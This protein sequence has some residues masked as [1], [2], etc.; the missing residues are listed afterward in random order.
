MT[1]L[2]EPSSAGAMPALRAVQAELANAGDPCLPDMPPEGCPPTQTCMPESNPDPRRSATKSEA[3]IPDVCMPSKCMPYPN[4]AS[5]A[6]SVSPRTQ[7]LPCVPQMD[8]NPGD[9][10]SC[11]PKKSS[12]RTVA[13]Q[14]VCIPDLCS[15]ATA[16]VPQRAV[17]AASFLWLDLTRKCQLECLHCYNSSGPDGD[18][19]TMTRDDWFSVLDQAVRTGVEMIQLIGG[20]PTMHPDFADLLNH[21]LTI[22]LKV[23]VFSNLVHVKPEWWELFQRSGVSLA[24]SYYAADAA[25][26]D[27]ITGRDSHRKTRANIEKATGLGIPLRAGVIAIRPTQNV[28]RTTGDLV[29][30]GVP[31]IGTDRLRHFGRGEQANPSCDV[32]ELC[33]NCGDR[34]A[35]IAPDGTVTPCIMSSWLKVGNVKTAPLAAI[36]AGEEMAA[37]VAL[38]PKRLAADPCNPGAECRPDAYPCQPQNE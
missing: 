29:S 15:P 22:G 19:G 20:E 7:A 12:V 38:I 16:C 37:A 10:W 26:H 13:N 27:A 5:A 8:C 25:E 30:L 23:E 11:E 34:R 21:A 2:E 31:T 35:A 18:H 9:Q 32:N 28:E 14:T 1:V 3:C 33:G 17:V 36:L 4:V 6:G 24:T